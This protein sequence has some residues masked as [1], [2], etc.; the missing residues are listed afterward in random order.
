VNFD[1]RDLLIA[2][3]F[4]LKLKHYEKLSHINFTMFNKNGPNDFLIPEVW[5]QFFTFNYTFTAPTR[6]RI[7]EA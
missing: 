2:I 6:M 3:F 5:Q 4:F 1:V 7:E